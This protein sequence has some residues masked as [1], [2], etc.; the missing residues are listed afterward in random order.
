MRTCVRDRSGLAVHSPPSRARPRQCH[1]G[2]VSGRRAPSCRPRR[3]ARARPPRMRSSAREIPAGGAP[4]ARALL[5]R[6]PRSLA[7]GGSGGPRHACLA[8]HGSRA[9][10][11]RALRLALPAWARESGRGTEH[12]GSGARLTFLR[13]PATPP[14]SEW[15]ASRVRVLVAERRQRLAPDAKRSCCASRGVP[16]ACARSLREHFLGVSFAA[17]RHWCS[18]DDAATA[19]G[20]DTRALEWDAHPERRKG[21]GVLGG[22]TLLRRTSRAVTVIGRK[23]AESLSVPA[24]RPGRRRHPRS[25]IL[26]P[27]GPSCQSR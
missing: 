20:L 25:R 7:R 22:P 16:R 5:P 10:S 3:S 6:D 12:L 14:D 11:E 26:A 23:G 2:P 8:S 21:P 13:P 19:G 4:L 27:A 18:S 15:P 24:S 9:G 17:A 1:R